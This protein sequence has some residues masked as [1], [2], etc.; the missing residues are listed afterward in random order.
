MQEVYEHLPCWQLT[1]M[2][3]FCKT[4]AIASLMPFRSHSQ[5]GWEEGS[6]GRHFPVASTSGQARNTAWFALILL[7]CVLRPMLNSSLEE[8]LESNRLGVFS[9]FSVPAIIE[10]QKNPNKQK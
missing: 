8:K 5:G 1:Y 9:C 6:D 3:L 7:I 4:K 10:N 2:P